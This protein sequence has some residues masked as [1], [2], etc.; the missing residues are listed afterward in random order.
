[1]RGQRCTALRATADRDLHQR[2]VAQPAKIVRILLA[3]G[4]R[5]AARHHH[6][7]HSC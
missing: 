4:D 5:R 1:L 7:E 3:A 6:F 2:I